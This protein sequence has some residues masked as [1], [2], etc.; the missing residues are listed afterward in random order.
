M[1]ISLQFPGSM[2]LEKSFPFYMELSWALQSPLG[3][4]SDIILDIM[5]ILDFKIIF[6]PSVIGVSSI[7]I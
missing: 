6:C 3:C 5:T 4:F 7:N 1:S 2:I